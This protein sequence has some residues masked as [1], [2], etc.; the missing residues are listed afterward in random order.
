ML[1]SGPSTLVQKILISIKY[2][3]VMI[4]FWGDKPLSDY[5]L[6]RLSLDKLVQWCHFI[7]P[8]H[9]HVVNGQMVPNKPTRAWIEW[10]RR[11][12]SN[13]CVGV[14]CVWGCVWG[15]CVCVFVCYQWERYGTS[16]ANL[17]NICDIYYNSCLS[18]HPYVVHFF[19]YYMNIYE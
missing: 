2:C 15:V 5:Q 11:W 7:M 14:W 3:Y 10:S 9:Q 8:L 18:Y 16:A 12:Y 4:S 1:I 19:L 17:I 6:Y 13:R